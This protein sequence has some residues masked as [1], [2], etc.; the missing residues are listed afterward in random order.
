MA[1]ANEDFAAPVAA[2]VVGKVSS[3]VI[4]LSYAPPHSAI[5][6][7]EKV[8]LWRLREKINGNEWA[9]KGGQTHLSISPLQ[10]SFR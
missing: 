8:K 2:K 10:T 5:I 3:V 4:R 9:P 7:G 1:L 6:Q